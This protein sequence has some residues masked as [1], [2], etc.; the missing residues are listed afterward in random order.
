MDFEYMDKVEYMH[1]VTNDGADVVIIDG[2]RCCAVDLSDRL[3]KLKKNK[4]IQIDR[5][6]SGADLLSSSIQIESMKQ[7]I[8]IVSDKMSKAERG[9]FKEVAVIDETFCGFCGAGKAVVINGLKNPESVLFA[10]KYHT[11]AV[12]AK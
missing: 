2:V 9:K 5:H 1:F 7:F 12:I 11:A 8:S 10:N 3:I 6:S 4:K